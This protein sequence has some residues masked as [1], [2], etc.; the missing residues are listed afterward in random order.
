MTNGKI[1]TYKNCLQ[2]I[3]CSPPSPDCYFSNCASFPGTKKVRE[4][5]EKAYED[6]AI[7]TVTYKEWISVDQCNLEI[8]QK[9]VSEF[10]DIFCENT[11]HLV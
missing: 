8:I 6:N 3:V 11:G 10:V 9:P 2:M 1:K 4:L 5:L 7:E